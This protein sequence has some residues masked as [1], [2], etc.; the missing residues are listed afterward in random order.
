MKGKLTTLTRRLEKLEMR[1]KHEVQA[2]NELFASHPACFHCQ[3]N[4]LLG[5][6]CPLVPSI[7]DLMQ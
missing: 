7:R 4:S 3:S 2:E 5:E 6:H 1:N